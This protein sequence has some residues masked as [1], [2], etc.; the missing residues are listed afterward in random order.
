[1][2]SRKKRAKKSAKKSSKKGMK[3]FW[4]KTKGT[5]GRG[6]IK[7]VGRK[8]PKSVKVGKKTVKVTCT[9]RKG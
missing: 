9:L 2:A 7:R 3:K 4:C 8:A 5:K 6:K 1:M